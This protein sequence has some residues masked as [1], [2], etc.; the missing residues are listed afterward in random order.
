MSL[1]RDEDRYYSI[2]GIITIVFCLSLC[3]HRLLLVLCVCSVVMCAIVCLLHR[4]HR[5]VVAWPVRYKRLYIHAFL[6][7]PISIV[8]RVSNRAAR[9]QVSARQDHSAASERLSRYNDVGRPSLKAT[10]IYHTGWQWYFEMVWDT[11]LFQELENLRFN[12]F[13]SRRFKG[14]YTILELSAISRFSNFQLKYS[15]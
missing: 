14:S 15:F 13:R 12:T 9:Q 3:Y 4:P 2:T 10:I 7:K 8:C 1:I 6:Y 5:F 11:N